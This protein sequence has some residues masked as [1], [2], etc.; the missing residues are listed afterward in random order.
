MQVQRLLRARPQQKVEDTTKLRMLYSQLG[1][2]LFCKN[3]KFPRQI[4]IV[5]FSYKICGD[6]A[7]TR[8]WIEQP[9]HV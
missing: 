8:S 9:G 4:L 5:F 2:K 6:G 3:K 1:R 7:S